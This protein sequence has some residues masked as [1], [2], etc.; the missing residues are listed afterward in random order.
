MKRSQVDEELE[1]WTG[2]SWSLG[3]QYRSISTCYNLQDPLGDTS[4]LLALDLSYS[5]FSVNDKAY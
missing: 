2:H 5:A 3:S 4:W 1:P